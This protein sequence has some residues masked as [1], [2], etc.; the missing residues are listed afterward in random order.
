MRLALTV[1]GGFLCIISPIVGLL[2][3]PGGI[4]VFAAGFA[5]ML[6]NSAIVRR[7]YARLKAKHPQKGQWVDWALRRRSARRRAKRD[8]ERRHEERRGD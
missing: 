8:R 7:V 2:P 4:F 3:G 6:K 1:F 5:L